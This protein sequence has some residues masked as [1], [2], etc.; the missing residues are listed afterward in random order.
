MT[1]SC[2][3]SVKG[4]PGVT[5]LA[6]LIGATWPE[7]RR[8]AVIEA[9]PSGGDLAARFQLATARGWSSFVTASRRSGRGVEIDTHLQALPGGLEVLV[10]P[11]GPRRVLTPHSVKDLIQGCQSAEPEPWD[12][13]V[14]G[15]R[16]MDMGLEPGDLGD[17]NPTGPW[18]DI[19]DTVVIVTRRDPASII[20]VRNHASALRRWGGD[21]LHLVLVGRGPHDRGAI[22]EFTGLPVIAEI[23]FDGAAAQVVTGEGGRSRQLSRSLLAAS[24]RRL[25]V[26]LAGAEDELDA[27]PARS[28]AVVRQ[29]TASRSVRL[30]RHLVRREGA[31]LVDGAVAG[32][33]LAC[34]SSDPAT[35]LVLDPGSATTVASTDETFPDDWRQGVMS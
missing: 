3:V 2:L 33:S 20:K 35:D 24:A 13:V 16:L 31:G 22:E 9:D 28:P 26:V 10:L 1:V 34:L 21:R 27:R 17:A 8:A 5:T 30:L 11:D 15:G 4:A 12:L 18:L 7:G 25:A 6:C 14:D 23:P 19:A 29:W 32:D